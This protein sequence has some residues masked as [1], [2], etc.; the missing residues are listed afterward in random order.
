MADA[1]FRKGGIGPGLILGVVGP[2]GAG[3]DTLIASARHSFRDRSDIIFPRRLITR[4]SDLTEDSDYLSASDFAAHDASGN[5]ALSWTAHGLAY[6]LPISID[7]A[8][9]SGHTVVV[10]LS[11]S[12]VPQVRARYEK[13]LILLVQ[14]SPAI[15]AS[16]IAARGRENE[17]D[18][19]A[20]LS[21][22]VSD[23][24]PADADLVIDNSGPLPEAT[25]R[26]A[27]IVLQTLCH[28]HGDAMDA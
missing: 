10:N 12:V 4:P 28:L 21:R 1:S 16:R 2:S 14:A 8:V 7:D 19:L 27:H 11:R 23:F 6:G 3:K 5:F 13:S 18:I 24:G 26:F 20:R 9:R 25:R 15:R 17:A 22:S